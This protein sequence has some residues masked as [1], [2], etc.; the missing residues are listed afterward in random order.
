MSMSKHT[1]SRMQHSRGTKANDKTCVS[2]S[3][4]E[5]EQKAEIRH[6]YLKVYIIF[7]F[8][9]VGFIYLNGLLLLIVV[10]IMC[11]VNTGF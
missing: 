1:A 2:Y 9:F 8:E 11:E 7:S 3:T 5:F 4:V 6:S 10:S